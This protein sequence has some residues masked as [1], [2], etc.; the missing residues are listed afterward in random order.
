[1]GYGLVSDWGTVSKG[2]QR[3]DPP[4]GVSLKWH[5]NQVSHQLRRTSPLFYRG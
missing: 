4:L 2:K 3:K 5:P 1:M